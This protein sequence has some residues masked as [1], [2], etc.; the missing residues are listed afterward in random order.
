[1]TIGEAEIFTLMFGQS[2]EVYF[3]FDMVKRRFLFINH[4]FEEITR[5]ECNELLKDPKSFFNLIHSED[6]DHVQAVF[7][8]L[9]RKKTHSLVDFR[10][11]RPDG[12]ERWVRL[13]VCPIIK[14]EKITFITGVMEDDSARKAA[15]YNMQIINGWKDS[16]LE[17]LAHD[18]RGPIGIVK[19]LAL[20]ISKKLPGEEHAQIREWTKMIAEIS[21]RNIKLIHKLI[22]KESLQSAGTE[23][24]KERI[25]I[26]EEIKEVMKIY[27]NSQTLTQKIFKF[28][29]SHEEIYARADSIKLIQVVNNL[30][31]NAIKFTNETGIIKLHIEKYD[32]TF[33]LTVEDNGIGIPKNLQPILFSKYTEA[34]REGTDG[35]SSI[36][37]GMWI[38]KSFTEAHD[39]KV[40]FESEQNK[41]SKFYVEIP[42]GEEE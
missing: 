20:E 26:V 32:K 30:V 21:S 2:E 42:L 17:I 34:G 1:M 40:W 24:T 31:S 27:K 37:L 29:S 15:I 12:S 28:T 38:I 3:I 25:N 19:M 5:R 39:G 6:K 8:N 7:K 16:L 10:I 9:L 36:G 13:K 22:K 23:I 41:G 4:A 14:E 33:M 11:L 35:Q 18:L